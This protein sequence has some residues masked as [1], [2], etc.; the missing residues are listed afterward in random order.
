[1]LKERVGV[2]GFGLKLGMNS[3]LVLYRFTVLLFKFVFQTIKRETDTMNFGT[4]NV[5]LYNLPN[6]EADE[7]MLKC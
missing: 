7:I 3:H 6:D 4:Q 5:V 1:M 2:G